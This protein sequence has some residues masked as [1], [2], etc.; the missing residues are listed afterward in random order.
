MTI[1]I[2][3]TKMTTSVEREGCDHPYFFCNFSADSYICQRANCLFLA[4]ELTGKRAHCK[5]ESSVRRFT[6]Q[7]VC[8]IGGRAGDEDLAISFLWKA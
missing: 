5:R 1:S 4:A 6:W 3:L 8:D 2:M 7:S